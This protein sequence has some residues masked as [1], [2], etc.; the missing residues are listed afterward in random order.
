MAANLQTDT[1][2]LQDLVASVVAST[3]LELVQLEL[4]GEGRGRLLR[5]FL[6]QPGGVGLEHCERASRALSA[7]LDE[8]E[9][10]AVLPGPYTLEVSSPGLDRMLVKH[11]DFER[12][13]GQR[14]RIKVRQLLAGARSWTGTLLG[15]APEGVRL[16][17]AGRSL[18]S[19]ALLIAWDN[20]SEARLAPIWPASSPSAPGGR[21]RSPGGK[22][23]RAARRK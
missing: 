9:G 2:R 21:G 4:R 20:L 19:E 7:A 3:G 23:A 8:V 6:D 1:G 10:A 18:E 16:Q 14:V 12:F 22:A 5:V 15:A 11:S 13:A 17:P